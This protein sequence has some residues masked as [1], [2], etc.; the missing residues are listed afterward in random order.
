DLTLTTTGDAQIQMWKLVSGSYYAVANTTST[1]IT[2]TSNGAGT[3]VVVVHSP[4]GAA[5]SYTL[6]LK[7]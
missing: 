3:Y 7:K 2:K 4:S 1:S 5:Q 6:T